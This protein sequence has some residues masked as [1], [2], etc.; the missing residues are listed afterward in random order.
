MAQEQRCFFP[1]L[2]HKTVAVVHIIGD[3]AFCSGGEAYLI[4]KQW[5]L[6]Y[7]QTEFVHPLLS[8]I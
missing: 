6:G 2:W 5:I 7:Y 3:I 4:A 8:H 1:T